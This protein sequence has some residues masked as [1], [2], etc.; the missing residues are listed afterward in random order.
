M[1]SILSIG[2]VGIPGVRNHRC[3]LIHLEQSQRGFAPEIYD[4]RAGRI[5]RDFTIPFRHQWAY[6]YRCLVKR[7]GFSHFGSF[8][9]FLRSPGKDTRV[10]CDVPQSEVFRS[11]SASNRLGGQCCR[12]ARNLA[13]MLALK[14]CPL[15]ISFVPYAARGK[16]FSGSS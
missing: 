8:F 9:N 3:L 11:A 16:A 2:G 5:E 1:R 10:L 14:S 12:V 15:D 13:K 4:L 7:T 6:E